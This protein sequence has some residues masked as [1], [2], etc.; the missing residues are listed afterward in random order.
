ML[1]S[2]TISGER[3]FKIIKTQITDEASVDVLTEVLGARGIINKVIKHLPLDQYESSNHQIFELCLDMLTKNKI[4]EH[5]T[6]H[7][8][9]D[10]LLE[11]ARKEEHYAMLVDWFESNLVKNTEGR[12]LSNI[13]LSLKHQHKM[14]ERIW[15]SSQIALEKKNELME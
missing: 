2:K 13:T 3:L 11:S 7:M 8:I 14:I 6:K 9:C 12:A 1:R 5:P 10:A 15:S 4:K